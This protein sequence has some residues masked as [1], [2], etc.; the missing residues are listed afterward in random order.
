LS[1][2]KK[3]KIARLFLL[4]VWSIPCAV[5]TNAQNELILVHPESGIRLVAV[6]MEYPLLKILLPNQPFTERGIEVE[7]PEHVTGV[8][9]QSNTIEHLYLVTRGDRNKRT[10]PTWR[11]D[12]NALVYETEL[13]GDVKMIARARLE[14]NGVHYSYQFTNHSGISYQ[15]FQAVTCVKLYDGFS[16]VLLERTYVHHPDGF[17]LLASETPERLNMPLQEW[18]PCR[19]L[20]SYSWPVPSKRMQKDEDSITRYTKSRKADK[21]LLATLSQDKK[22]IAATY[23]SETGNLWTNPERSCQHADPSTSLNPGETKSLRLT[24]FLCKGTLDQL[25]KLVNDER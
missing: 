8:M 21:P 24:T 6:N 18:L 3:N 4:V 20:V 2:T 17:D 15:K 23:T 22:W 12:G 11:I 25:L 16:D 5:K 10:L 13:N 7:F 9:Q 1:I 14:P 19:Y